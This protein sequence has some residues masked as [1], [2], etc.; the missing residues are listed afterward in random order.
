MLNSSN[1]D[2]TTISKKFQMQKGNNNAELKHLTNNMEGGILP[3]N[4]ER[5]LGLAQTEAS[6]S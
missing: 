1:H 5:D 3:L 2:L 6:S 4:G